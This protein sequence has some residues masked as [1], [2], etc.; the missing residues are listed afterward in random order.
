MTRRRVR[1]EGDM[2]LDPWG[3]GGLSH[4]VAHAWTIARARGRM[5]HTAWCSARSAS[6]TRLVAIS[7]RCK[8]KQNIDLAAVIIATARY[9]VSSP[10]RCYLV[11][12]PRDTLLLSLQLRRI[13]FILACAFT[14]CRIKLSSHRRPCKP[15]WRRK[16][17][18]LAR[19]SM[20]AQ[21][22]LAVHSRAH[23][24]SSCLLH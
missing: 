3:T 17:Q 9:I 20:R 4:H 7:L 12:C 14:Q 23:G 2:W 5:A 16:K 22:V 19:V 15:K 1:C 18:R 13:L 10:C 11:A 24:A 8:R 6:G 21:K